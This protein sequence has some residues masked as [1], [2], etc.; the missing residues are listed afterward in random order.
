M[1]GFGA[2]QLKQYHGNELIEFVVLT[3]EPNL[4]QFNGAGSAPSR[5]MRIK[6]PLDIF[7]GIEAKFSR[8][9]QHTRVRRRRRGRGGGTH[10]CR[11]R[12]LPRSLCTFTGSDR[13]ALT[14]GF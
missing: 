12:V 9:L 2:L 6:M 13:L 5:P 11:L 1:C 7:R 4:R 14:F 3:I 8:R 10:Y